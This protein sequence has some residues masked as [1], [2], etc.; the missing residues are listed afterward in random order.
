MAETRTIS[1]LLHP[2]LLDETGL[3]I[4]ARWYIEGFASAA[5]FRSRVTLRKIFRVCRT[6]WNWPSFAFARVPDKYPS[7][8]QK[9]ACR[10]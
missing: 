5:A 2:P 8:F 7:S 1:Y 9:C 10:S 3:G 6:P 4:A